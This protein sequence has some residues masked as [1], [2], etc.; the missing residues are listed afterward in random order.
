MRFNLFQ[1][2]SI[3]VSSNLQADQFIPKKVVDVMA[4]ELAESAR[5]KII[6]RVSSGKFPGNPD[7]TGPVRSK[8]YSTGTRSFPMFRH[9]DASRTRSSRYEGMMGRVKAAAEQPGN[10]V[11]SWRSRSGNPWVYV[12]GGYS[13]LRS[14]AGLPSGSVTLSFTGRLMEDLV[15][16]PAVER[17]GESGVNAAASAVGGGKIRTGGVGAGFSKSADIDFGL[18]DVIASIH[19]KIGFSTQSSW[20][21]ARWQAQRYNNHFALL[22]PSEKTDLKIEGMRLAKKAR[23]KFGTSSPSVAPRNEKGQFIPIDL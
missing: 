23:G 4:K 11:N 17:F 8:S 9:G 16:K 15:V 2:D 22:T 3:Q 20:Q 6:S 18:A 13:R 1:P 5:D 7:G 12:P 19:L 10:G 21:V 14:L